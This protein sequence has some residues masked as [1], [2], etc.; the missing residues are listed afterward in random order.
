MNRRAHKCHKCGQNFS[1][2]R[3]ED[4]K[5]MLHQ[6]C[7]ECSRWRIGNCDCSYQNRCAACGSR[8]RTPS[9]L[10]KHLRRPHHKCAT[11]GDTY[12]ASQ[13]THHT[14]N[15]SSTTKDQCSQAS[16]PI[17]HSEQ[18][19]TQTTDR[20]GGFEAS[21]KAAIEKYTREASSAV[22]RFKE[23]VTTQYKN[24]PVESRAREDYRQYQ[25]ILREGNLGTPIT[26]E[27]YS[28]SAW[29]APTDKFVFCSAEQ[30]RALFEQGPPLLPILIPAELNIPEST[31]RRSNENTRD[32]L[33]TRRTV[34]LQV[35]RKVGPEKE[36]A[37]NM[38]SCEAIN[39]LAN[40]EIF[41]PTNALNLLIPEDNAVPSCLS[42]LRNWDL[43]L[44]TVPDNGKPQ[45]MIRTGWEA[46]ARF[47]LLA[48]AGAVS[49]KHTDRGGVIT[50]VFCNE[51]EKLWPVWPGLQLEHLRAYCE[52][53][54]TRSPGVLLYMTA[55]DLLIQPQGT[56]HSPGTIRE[57]NMRG[58]MHLHTH[59]VLGALNLTL[60]EIDHPHIT[61]EDVCPDFVSLMAQV[62]DK[63]K[64]G[65]GPWTWGSEEEL[66]E[67][68]IILK[69][70]TTAAVSRLC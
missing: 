51:G 60:L 58:T 3:I 7:T 12:L 59:Q 44:S 32:Y 34:D 18:Q 5:R 21:I 35:Y 9:Q 30:A 41:G 2:T 40:P 20:R 33:T 46:S 25:P 62:L 14:L 65:R 52:D 6:K 26:A 49:Q 50:T 55:G 1:A 67:A 57:T 61:N 45:T 8:F 22:E 28:K 47:D 54:E 66:T 29:I 4:H 11:C 15:C 63:W 23:I 24:A 48:S 53:L 27:E 17:G 64:D 38:K 69:V 39:R 19:H 42:G 56:L 68:R 16:N 10:S 43:L 31:H 13:K 37:D 70:R 36:L